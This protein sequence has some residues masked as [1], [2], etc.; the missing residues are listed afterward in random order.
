MAATITYEDVINGFNTSVPEDIIDMMIDALTAA[1][2]CLDKNG[3]PV[4]KQKLLKLYAIRHQLVLMGASESGKGA[5]S[6]ETAPSG[7]S[8]S[9]RA[10]SGMGLDSTS[11]GALLK[12][13][14]TT[15]CIVSV[16]DSAQRMAV[17]SVG[18]R[19]H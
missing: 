3:V 12:Q 5:V 1:D 11:Y 2:E 7:A 16:I 4:G 14:D 6:S 18:R 9:Y 13:A 19:A 17:M 10:P 15:G 8:R